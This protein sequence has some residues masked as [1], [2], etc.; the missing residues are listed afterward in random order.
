M[1]LIGD[2]VCVFGF[3]RQ[4]HFS[5]DCARW[6]WMWGPDSLYL[7][8]VRPVP[9]ISPILICSRLPLIQW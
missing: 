8:T 6:S 7:L 9:F 5:A 1:S 2:D 3:Y 4:H